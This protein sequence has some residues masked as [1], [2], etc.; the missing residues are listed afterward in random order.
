M[1]CGPESS[2]VPQRKF[3]VSPVAVMPIKLN[4]TGCAQP[5]SNSLSFA[6]CT[7][8]TRE[9]STEEALLVARKQVF[10]LCP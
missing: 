7:S 5:V 4:K 3:T 9:V 2:P 8:H 10:K 6:V 1:K